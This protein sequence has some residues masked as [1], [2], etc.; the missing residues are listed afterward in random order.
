[1]SRL[2]VVD[3][4]VVG[5]DPAFVLQALDAGRSDRLVLALDGPLSPLT[6]R[7]AADDGAFSLLMPVDA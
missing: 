7:P 5:V 6:I 3:G 1:M 2:E 4:S